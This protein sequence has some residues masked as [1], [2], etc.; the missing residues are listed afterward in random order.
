[1][2]IEAVPNRH[3]PPA[4]LLRESYREGGKI[5]KRTLLNL[6]DWPADRIAGFKMLLKGGTVIPSNQ[7]A[8]TIIRSLPHGHV[9]AAL[10]TARKIGLDRLLGPDGNRC[11]DLV[12]ALVISRLLEPGSKLAAARAL[13]PDTASSS[14]GQQLGLGSVDEDELYT[15]LDWLAVRQPAIETALAKDHLAGGTLVLYDV[16]SSY[17]EGRCCPLAQYGYNRDGKRGKLQIIYGL[18]CAADGAPVAIEVFEGSTADPMTLTSQV[19]K[20]KQRFGLDHVVLVGDRGMITQARITADLSTA[21][22]DW[23]TALRAPAIKALR[24]AGALQMSLFD[25]RDMASI[26]SPDFPGERLIVCRNRALAAER[27]RRREDLL[28]AT[29]RELARIAAAVARQRQPLR[30]AA[31][32]GLKVGAVLD[33]HKMAKHFTLDIADDRFGFARKTEEI[34]AEAALDG[35]YVVRT[36]LPATVL[37]DPTTVR[38]YK[39]LS[40]VERAFRCLKSVDLQIRP[41]YHWLA[42]RVRAH[43]F[44]C[45]LAYYL[46]WHMR[47]R[48]APML[49]DDTD[50]D[51]AQAQRASVVAKAERS[52][53]AV[54]KQTTGQTEDGLPVHSFRTLLAD[55]AT[56]TRNTLVTAIDPER[57]FT[58]TARPTALQHKALDLLGLSRTQ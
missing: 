37:D 35:I 46:E 26:T 12:L 32:I 49:Y 58:L 10:G 57:S 9:A 36:S 21:G 41:V 2:Y 16:S 31:A 4:I 3:S 33:Q 15:A 47:Q 54:T 28:A 8:I 7:Q 48:L 19:T 34:A 18:L 20:L 55:L 56:L 14:L 51:A 24:D 45:M 39:S 29:E 27:A 17:M 52:P 11:R 38:S 53:A 22:L 42:D 23:I 25:E 13:S 40:L 50:K 30:G 5:R 6:S 43:V 44:L 1:M